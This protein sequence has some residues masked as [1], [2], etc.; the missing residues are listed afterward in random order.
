MSQKPP[1]PVKP[2]SLRSTTLHKSTE[3]TQINNNYLKVNNFQ[4]RNAISN[5]EITITQTHS[6]VSILCY[7]K[8]IL[9]RN[10]L[11]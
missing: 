6:E 11:E 3:N 4:L 7:A 5:P 8:V 2:A 9:L 10:R 1:K